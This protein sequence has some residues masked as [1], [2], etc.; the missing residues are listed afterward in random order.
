MNSLKLY[1]SCTFSATLL[2]VVLTGCSNSGDCSETIRSYV[3]TF[4]EVNITGVSNVVSYRRLANGDV[5]AADA[6]T[7][8]SLETLVID[9]ILK[10]DS[11]PRDT[12]SAGIGLLD[13][14]IDSAQACS[15]ALYRGDVES[16]IVTADLL[17]TTSFGNEFGAGES[18]AAA[19]N[20]APIATNGIKVGDFFDDSQVP[21]QSVTSS[22][23]AIGAVRYELYAQTPL[24]LA[25]VSDELH[26]FTFSI[27]LDTGEMFTATTDPVLISGG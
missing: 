1:R 20:I 25:P 13:W 22:E 14:F 11:M 27:S 4:K 8:T 2:A 12:R 17:S 16:T 21:M 10:Y 3:S 26:Q 15:P 23:P 6:T 9:V 18:L 24:K 7:P 5:V 19:F